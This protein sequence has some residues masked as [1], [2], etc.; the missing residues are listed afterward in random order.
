MMKET[1][2]C[3]TCICRSVCVK[4][5]DYADL[6]AQ[7]NRLSEKDLSFLPSLYCK[8]FQRENDKHT[9]SYPNF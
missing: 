4:R 3:E 2:Q 1:A 9:R 5:E 6:Y 7:L 8:H